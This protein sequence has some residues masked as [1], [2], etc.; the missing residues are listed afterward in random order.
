MNDMGFPYFPSPHFGYQFVKS[1]KSLFISNFG[2]IEIV[3]PG[4][5]DISLVTSPVVSSLLTLLAQLVTKMG[6]D[7]DNILSNLTSLSYIILSWYLLV[8]EWL[9]ISF[10]ITKSFHF[11]AGYSGSGLDTSILNSVQVAVDHLEGRSLNLVERTHDV[12][13]AFGAVEGERTG[14]PRMALDLRGVEEW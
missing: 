9:M 6:N 5:L 12:Y 13:L 1:L 11:T 7:I 10:G 8:F 3:E 14:G 4:R 2:Y